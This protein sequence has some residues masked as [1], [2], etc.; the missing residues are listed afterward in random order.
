MLGRPAKPSRPAYTDGSGRY[1]PAR[2]AQP[3]KPPK[4]PRPP[5]ILE[6][7]QPRTS[8]NQQPEP[9]PGGKTTGDRA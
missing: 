2:P 8:S 4:A 5:T 1:H 3:P 6:P 9:K 7:P